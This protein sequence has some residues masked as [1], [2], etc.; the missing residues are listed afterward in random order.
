MRN[1][2]KVS[3]LLLLIIGVSSFVS[4]AYYVTDPNNCPTSYQSQTCSGSDHVCGYSG[5]VTYC[6]DPDSVN[7][8]T[9]DITT[10]GSGGSDLSCEDTSCSGGF[11]IDCYYYDGIAPHCD[12]D[13]TGFCDRNPTCYNKHVQTTC[14]KDV[15]VTS[16]CSATCTTNYFYC[17]GSSGDTDGCEIHTGDS[18]GSGTGTIVYNQCVGSAGNCTSSTRLD[19]DDSDSDGDPKTCNSGNGCEILIGG[20]CTVGTLSGTYGNTCTG[21]A[22]TCQ[23]T[24]QDFISSHLTEF[25]SNSTNPF[26]W[27]LDY[28]LGTLINLSWSVGGGFLVNSSGAYFNNTLLGSGSGTETDPYWTGNFTAYNTSWSSIINTSYYLQSNP[29][30][31]WNTTFANFNKTYADTLYC[32][33]NEPLW[34]ANYTSLNAT[35]SSVTNTSYYLVSNPFG[36]YNSTNKHDIASHNWANDWMIIYS[37]GAGLVELPFGDKS[38]KFLRSNGEGALTWET[39]TETDPFWNGNQTSVLN[40]SKWTGN[41]TAYNNSWTSTINTS[42]R[43]LTN[44]TF[45]NNITLTSSNNCIVNNTLNSAY[46]CHNGTGWII[47]G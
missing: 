38:G 19:C 45:T 11:V 14:T 43:T 33:I 46:I 27:G 41:F 31:Y 37:N 13:N 4:S 5:G 35:W 47:R 8:P 1:S 12:N 39:P 7:P 16:S 6:Y 18:C 17:D 44:G 9:S 28:N 10:T 40:E 36:F 34:T 23:L 24:P 21:S 20:A 26:L 2:I 42:Y 30:S 29:F 22:G 32:T 3:L 25:Q 15:F